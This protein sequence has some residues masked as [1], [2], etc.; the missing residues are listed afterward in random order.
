[1]YIDITHSISCRIWVA[2]KMG[3]KWRFIRAN[4]IIKVSPESVRSVA[5]STSSSA[6]IAEKLMRKIH[7]IKNHKKIE[8]N[9][10]K[11]GSIWSIRPVN[12]QPVTFSI[13]RMNQNIGIS[14]PACLQYF[15]RLLRKIA[16][17]HY[18]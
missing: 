2:K 6:K 5:L 10:K 13:A 16:P 1:M 9:S 14:R 17:L 3:I 11:V 18:Q 15:K 4:E 8:P 7:A 12:F